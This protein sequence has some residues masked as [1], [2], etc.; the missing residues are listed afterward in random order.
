MT[1]M[2]EHA[3]P[4]RE[5]RKRRN[6]ALFAFI[7]YLPVVFMTAWVSDRLIHTSGP[8][9]VVMFGWLIFGAVANVRCQR[10][11]CPRC[12]KFF[13]IKYGWYEGRNHPHCVHCGLAKYTPPA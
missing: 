2:D 8:A 7:A 13:F 4:W 12:G 6:L 11:E 10:F 9:I 3:D 1:T 5:Y